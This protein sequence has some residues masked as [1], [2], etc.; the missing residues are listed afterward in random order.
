MAMPHTARLTQAFLARHD[1]N[2]LPWS[3][4]SPEMNPIEH[5]WDLL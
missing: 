1:V 4:C 3:A 2:V 5:L